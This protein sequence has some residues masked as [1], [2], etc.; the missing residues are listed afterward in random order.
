MQPRASNDDP[1]LEQLV[2]K[3]DAALAAG[4]V[5]TAKDANERLARAEIAA[6][7]RR[8]QHLPVIVHVELTTRCSCSCIMCSRCYERV[9]ERDLN[10]E[11]LE[12]LLPCARVAVINGV[13]EP[14]LH[15]RFADV[16][17]LLRK[18]GVVASATTNL[19]H[20]SREHIPLIAEVFGRVGV[21]CDGATARTYES[22]R[23]GASFERLCD[24]A[25][26]LT[27]SCPNTQF[28]LAVV[29]MRQ[30]IRESEAIVEL[31]ARLG[32]DSVRFGRLETNRL[33]ENEGDS[34]MCFPDFARE[35]LGRALRRGKELGVEVSV[36]RVLRG[37]ADPIRVEKQ[38]QRLVERPLFQPDSFYEALPA[39]YAELERAGLFEPRPYE[40]EPTVDSEGLCH[41]LG[42]GT[43][44]SVD[45][46]VRPCGEIVGAPE[47]AGDNEYNPLNLPSSRALR[48][49]FLGG[50]VPRACANCSYLM[51][52]ELS[53]VVLDE[54]RLFRSLVDREEEK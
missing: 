52:D 14:L 22:I 13:G 39:R 29:S 9:A 37:P 15:P 32:F 36:P 43:Y 19:Q 49:V 10:V 20:L 25:R 27:S 17:E 33:L 8:Y 45:G 53:S 54:A 46:E 47:P 34:L 5:A 12:G 41:W 31:A 50:H 35:H 42:L 11:L 26:L 51:N 40:L 3:R 16:L 44:V 7:A 23:R 4:D 24:N 6:G 30:N 21:S 18:Y 38:A 28:Q 48:E 1:T 2:A